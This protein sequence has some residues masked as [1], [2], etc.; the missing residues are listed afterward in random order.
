MQGNHATQILLAG[1]NIKDNALLLVED[2][3]LCGAKKMG[4]GSVTELL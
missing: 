2:E 1:Y 3:R 4:G